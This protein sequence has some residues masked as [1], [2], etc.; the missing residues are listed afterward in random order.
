MTKTE[1]VALALEKGLIKNKTAG[2]K[3]PVA[4]LE[5]LVHVQAAEEPKAESPPVVFH[6]HQPS[7]AEVGHPELDPPGEE[8][9]VEAVE[10]VVK[11]SPDERL[12]RLR[13]ALAS[14]PKGA[15]FTARSRR[16]L[17]RGIRKLERT[18][19]KMATT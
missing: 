7:F 13:E 12:A 4:E 14:F 9:P 16:R 18:V 17:E 3:M 11:A 5:K 1:M 10:A 2:M 15:P 19:Q 6:D 8:V